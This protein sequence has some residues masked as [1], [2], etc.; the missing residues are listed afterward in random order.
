MKK[1]QF[2]IKSNEGRHE[3]V[4]S[5]HELDVII[6]YLMYEEEVLPENFRKKMLKE[7]HQKSGCFFMALGEHQYA[8]NIIQ[9][10]KMPNQSDNAPCGLKGKFRLEIGG[11]VLDKVLDNETKE[12]LQEA[13]GKELT[14]DDAMK[15][16]ARSIPYVWGN[17]YATAVA[18]ID[19][20]YKQ[21]SKFTPNC[22]KEFVYNIGKRGE[23]YNY[24]KIACAA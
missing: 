11:D 14:F 16:I 2:H 4:V 18:E 13:N 1:F 12:W 21:M 9:L 19:N 3:C 23:Y 20:I 24:I 8:L 7:V 17:D 15:V 10:P 6:N 5:K 22:Y